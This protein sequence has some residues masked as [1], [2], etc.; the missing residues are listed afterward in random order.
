MAGETVVSSVSFAG[1]KAYE[2]LAYWS[3]RPELHFDQVASVRPTNQTHAGGTV[4]FTVYDD[5]VAATSALNEITDPA[6]VE[7]G[8]SVVL[9]TLVEYG[10]A[11]LTTAKAR[12]TDIL[13]LDTDVA[14]LVGYQAGI[15]ID[16]LARDELSAGTN[17]IAANGAANVGAVVAADTIKPRDIAKVVAKLRGA[18]SRP[19]H[20]GCYVGFFHPDQMLDLR[21][22]TGAAGWLEVAN[23]TED[24][25]RR[26]NAVTGKFG[27]VMFVETPR[28]NIHTDGGAAAVDLYDSVVVG[29]Q[30]LAKAHAIKE[31]YQELPSIVIGP[32]V[33]SLRRH[34]TIGWKWLGG[35]ERFREAS[36]WRIESASSVGIN[37]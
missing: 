26:W 3:L 7:I 4:E 36:I 15:S 18:N 30:A 16:T 22:E 32:Q 9:V 29:E 35:Y 28:V 14:A 37:V 34:N 31:G 8:D 27:G 5:M 10:S 6:L 19:I 11:S 20:D 21:A 17:V 25:S 23:Q 12:A 24:G 33:D 13:D 2:Q 1:T